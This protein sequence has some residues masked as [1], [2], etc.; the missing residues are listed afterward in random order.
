[1]ALW[2]YILIYQNFNL[3][4]R[5][6]ELKMLWF[7][8]LPGKTVGKTVSFNAVYNNNIIIFKKIN[9]NQD[10]LETGYYT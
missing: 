3:F 4:Y 9:D 10:L 5:E 6:D 1:M 8:R 7:T 2:F